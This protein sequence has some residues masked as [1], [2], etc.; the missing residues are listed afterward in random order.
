[1]KKLCRERRLNA[2][3]VP[4][5]P[6][7]RKHKHRTQSTQEVEPSVVIFQTKAEDT[8]ITGRRAS[9]IISHLWSVRKHT[10]KA[11]IMSMAKLRKRVNQ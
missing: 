6:S 1:M 8:V 10:Y 11:K 4:E 5:T 2:V 7:K 9:V 3:A